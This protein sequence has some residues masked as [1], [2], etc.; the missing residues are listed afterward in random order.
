MR[1]TKNVI[2]RSCFETN[3]SSMHSILVTKND[4]HV[5]KDD[6]L[7][8]RNKDIQD[9]SVYIDSSGKWSLYKIED[10]YGRWPFQVLTTFEEKFKYAMCAYLG[11]LYEDDPEWQKWYDEFKAI[12]KEMLPGFQDFYMDKKDIDIYLDEDGNE[13]QQKDLH[14]AGWYDEKSHYTYTD[15]NGDEKPAILDEENYLE[16]PDIGMIDHESM[17]VLQCFI[18]SHG[19]DLKEFLTNKKYVIVVDGDEYCDFD[20]YLRSGLIDKDF[21]TERYR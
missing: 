3:S 9:D 14:Y 7:W 12:A 19:I 20:K 13:I 11:Y 1:W 10:G 8:D 15:K 16:M 18:N 6:L 4:M 2:R 17:G 21:I 5:N